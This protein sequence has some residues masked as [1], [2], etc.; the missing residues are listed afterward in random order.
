MAFLKILFIT[1]CCLLAGAVVFCIVMS[2]PVSVWAAPIVALFGLVYAVPVFV[3]IAVLWALYGQPWNSLR[4][5][6]I[7]CLCTAC[8]GGCFMLV[9]GVRDQ[10]AHPWFY[11]DLL[12]GCTGGAMG[13][14]LVTK[15]KRYAA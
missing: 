14:Y 10:G 2:G 7:L 11:A 5:R 6:I 13:A 15:L 4:A 1:V 12:G 9:F 3:V 8:V